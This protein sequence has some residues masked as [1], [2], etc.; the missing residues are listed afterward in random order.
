MNPRTPNRD[1]ASWC[2][3]QPNAELGARSAERKTRW[4][5]V[6]IIGVGGRRGMGD[7]HEFNV[8]TPCPVSFYFDFR[9]EFRRACCGPELPPKPV[10][11]ASENPFISGVSDAPGPKITSKSIL[12]D[13]TVS[14]V[15][16]PLRDTAASCGATHKIVPYPVAA[17][18]GEKL[19]AST[20]KAP[21]DLLLLGRS[22][23]IGGISCESFRPYRV[24][25]GCVSPSCGKRATPVQSGLLCQQ[26]DLQRLPG[27]RWRSD[28]F[29]CH[30]SQRE[31]CRPASLQPFPRLRLLRVGPHRVVDREHRVIDRER[32][33][34]FLEFGRAL[35]AS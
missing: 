30:Q 28:L 18:A 26:W 4:W 22:R 24:S 12:P 15:A 25:T 3:G 23:S 16:V 2:V 10:G 9:G 33:S 5:R 7:C 19:T 14:F 13:E 6:A 32:R 8:F 34:E 29:S 1:I 27:K 11:G 35:S 20:L 31:A 17:Q 21:G